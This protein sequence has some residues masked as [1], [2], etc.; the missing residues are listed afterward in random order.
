[1]TWPSAGRSCSCSTRDATTPRSR[2]R[3][4][5]ARRPSRASPSGSTTAPAAIA[6]RSPAVPASRC[7]PRVRRTHAGRPMSALST[8]AM[9]AA[10]STVRDPSRLRLA[11]PNKGRLLEPTAALLRDAG[12]DFED[13][14]RALVARIDT[15]PLDILSVRTD[16]IAEFVAD[17]VADLG[18]TGT[19]LLHR[20]RCRP[21]GRS[22]SWA[23]AAA[24]WRP[25][26]PATARRARSRTCA[27]CASPPATPT[28][29]G[30]RSRSA[31]S[32]SRS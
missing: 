14:T 6:T 12:L 25:P 10:L 19:N 5:P 15:F 18:I 4:A 28:A 24:A 30:R 8:A 26:C 3:P 7:V 29:P 21:A 31:A 27:G 16:D 9:G 11:V 23:T 32:R 17:G 1:M 13:G 22:W 20:G 2:A